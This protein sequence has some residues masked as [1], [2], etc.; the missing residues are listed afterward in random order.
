MKF[1][2]FIENAL[3]SGSNTSSKRLNGTIGFILVQLVI[4]FAVGYCYIENGSISSLV[5]GLIE[6]NLYVSAGLLGLGGI[7]E[8]VKA[9]LSK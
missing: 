7:I 5:A 1:W 4:L 2:I 9:K 6:T 3:T 8:G